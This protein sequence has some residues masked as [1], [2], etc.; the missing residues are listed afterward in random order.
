TLTGANYTI[1]F[2]GN[3]LAITPAALSVLA[4]RQTK[5][6]G[7]ADPA[8]TYQASGLKFNDTVAT[9]LTGALARASGENVGPYAITPGTLA[10]TNYTINFTSN[11][12]TITA[13]PVTV[14]ADAKAKVYGTADPALTYKITAGSL[15]NSDSFSGTLTRSAVE[16]AGTHT[17]LQGSLLLSTNY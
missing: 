4:N 17:I 9:A 10:P 14:A 13:R 5:I 7:A 12:L 16:D 8:L 11:T 3:N 15:V 2:T 6:Y 1:S